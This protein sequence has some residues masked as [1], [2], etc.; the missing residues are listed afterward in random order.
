MDG[1][2]TSNISAL[3]TSTRIEHSTHQQLL[4][5]DNLKFKMI[6]NDFIC[7]LDEVQDVPQ[8]TSEFEPKKNIP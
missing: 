4:I 7:C 5:L 2:L 1:S 3:S 6:I 8:G